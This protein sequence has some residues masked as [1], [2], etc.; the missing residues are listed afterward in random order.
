MVLL[1][2]HASLAAG[3]SGG[4]R[5]KGCGTLL[6]AGSISKEEKQKCCQ[7]TRVTLAPRHPFATRKANILDPA[8][9]AAGRA[10]VPD[11]VACP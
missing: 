7:V 6:R 2:V 3:D 9:A 4:R 1:Q 5:R 8:R 10:F 11:N